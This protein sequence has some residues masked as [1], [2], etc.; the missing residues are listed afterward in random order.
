MFRFE[1]LYLQFKIIQQEN[2]KRE[3]GKMLTFVKSR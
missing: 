3:Y 2:E 1:M